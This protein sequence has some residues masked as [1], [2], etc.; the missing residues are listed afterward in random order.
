MT[1]PG[2]PWRLLGFIGLSLL[3]HTAL[4]LG[5][6]SAPPP[7]SFG[8]PFIHAVLSPATAPA[9]AVGDQPA[10]AS[11]SAHPA[12]PPAARSEPI[13][14]APLVKTPGTDGVPPAEAP[15][16]TPEARDAM[17]ETPPDTATRATTAAP[18]PATVLRAPAD[19]GLADTAPVTAAAERE[20]LRN[21]LLGELQ[22]RLSQHLSYPARAR[23]RGWEGEVLLGLR[24]D[25]D[26]WLHDIR[27]L[28]GSGHAIL[29]RDALRA[30][31][32]VERLPLPANTSAF[33]S[34]ELRLPVVYRLQAG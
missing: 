13:T 5:R 31:R 28:H 20:A 9:P 11:A 23:R 34:L 29:D 21:Q 12:E 10:P 33:P 30:L 32:R 4:L 16:S 22:L 2:L 8:L 14:Q 27:L 24:I 25:R 3:L 19:N 15:P 7:R 6:D 18:P 17:P 1:P 26:G